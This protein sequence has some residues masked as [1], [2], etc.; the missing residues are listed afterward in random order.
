MPEA[1]PQTFNHFTL[2]KFTAAYWAESPEDRQRIHRGWIDG[3]C[4]ASDAVHLY[5]SYGLEAG[6]DLVVWCARKGDDTAIPGRFFTAF[7]SVT[8]P[9]RR[10]I[11]LRETLWGFTKPS[12]YTKT[13]STQE[14]DPFAQDRRPYLVM[15][16]FVKT[17]D[18]YLKER[19]ERQ[20]MMLGHIKIGKQYPD[21]AQLLLYSYGLQDQEFVVVYET[22]DLM[23]FLNLVTELRSTE[24]RIFT[25][26]DYP[27]H[28]AIHQPGVEA[29][30][31][32]L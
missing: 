25:E 17:T 30:A 1:T 31:T 19:E 13:R 23:R 8:A 5:Q 10:D 16:P 29:L 26:R 14:L 20:R 4:G 21:I 12:Q 11:D 2:I 6:S 22:Y 15:Y 24:A 3:L 18:W 32:W 28:A 7:S 9:V 27:L